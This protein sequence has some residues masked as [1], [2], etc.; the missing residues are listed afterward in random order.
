MILAKLVASH[1]RK[2]F[3]TK[4]KESI[5]G[6]FSKRQ[7]VIER[8]EHI[9]GMWI[10]RSNTKELNTEQ[11]ITTYKDLKTIEASFRVIKDILELRPI[12]HHKDERVKGHI[13]IC[14]LAFLVTKILEKKTQTTIK[15]LREEHLTSV[16]IPGATRTEPQQIIGGEIF[17]EQPGVGV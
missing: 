13:F 12:Y 8:E 3:D 11:L 4:E 10:I 14:I 5:T 16:I 1:A 2:Y 6:L 17:L 9:D 7:E 15:M